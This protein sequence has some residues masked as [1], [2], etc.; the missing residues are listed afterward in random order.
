[1]LPVALPD[2]A[3]ASV[4]VFFRF[5]VLSDL[6]ACGACVPSVFLF[7]FSCCV[8]VAHARRYSA[9]T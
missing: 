7:F 2:T 8:V 4:F 5:L 3:Q 9:E 6:V 1:M